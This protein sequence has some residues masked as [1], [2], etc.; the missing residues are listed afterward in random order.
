VLNNDGGGIFEF[1]P[2]AEMIDRDEFE[3]LF[4][5]PSGIDPADLAAAYRLPHR[6]IESF[7]ELEE[8]ANAGTGIIEMR[9]GRKANLELH[10]RISERVA[11]ELAQIAAS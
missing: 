10:R 4:G 7:S 8:A 11:R 3:S 5:T 6:R 9:T 1:L 2:Q